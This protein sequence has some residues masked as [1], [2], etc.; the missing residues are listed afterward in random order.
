[1]CDDWAGGNTLNI[2]MISDVYFPRVNGV[3]TSIRTFRRE[4]EQRGHHVGLIAPAYPAHEDTAEQVLRM[5]AR[6]L[7]LDPEDRLMSASRIQGLEGALRER[8][9]D[10]IHIQ[11][12][13]AAHRAGVA[14]ARRLGLPVVETYHTFFEEYFYHYIPF[15]PKSLLR[16]AARRLSRHQCNRLDALVVPSRAMQEALGAYGVDVPMAVIPTGIDLEKFA[17]GDGAAFRASHGI[18]PERPLLLFVGRVAF[19]K[20]IGFLLEAMA[21]IKAALPQALLVIAGEG[22][23]LPSLRRRAAALGL[24]DNVLFIGYLRNGADLRACYRAADVFVFA[25][26]TETQGLVLLEA[27]ALGVPVVAL[28]A[29]GTHDIL[30]AGKGALTPRDDPADFAAQALRLLGDAGL[31]ERLGAQGREYVRQW[32]AGAMAESMLD[33]YRTV[34][35][36]HKGSTHAGDN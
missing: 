12:P 16:L 27:M 11:T 29:M 14:L 21:G 20:N 33:F 26:R 36:R 31:R 30:D 19:E 7:P 25:S 8:E 15:L 18:A 1:M 3:S 6:A 22:P 35:A 13:F 23:A 28:A 34:I 5:S 10:L 4:L 17:G 32:T 2:L 24:E 9:F